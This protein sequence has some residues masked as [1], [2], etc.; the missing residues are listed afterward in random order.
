MIEQVFTKES[1]CVMNLQQ[2][3]FTYGLT[4]LITLQSVSF[5]VSFY[6][7]STEIRCNM[8]INSNFIQKS[9]T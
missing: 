9:V 6:R 1:P 5:P 4:S 2:K 7:C 8:T 3:Q